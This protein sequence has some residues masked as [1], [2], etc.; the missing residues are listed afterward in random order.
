MSSPNQLVSQ[1]TQSDT[2][3][4]RLAYQPQQGQIPIKVSRVHINTTSTKNPIRDNTL[5][6]FINDTILKA[7]TLSD[8]AS[9]AEILTKRLHQSH[10]IKGLEPVF[11]ID[12]GYEDTLGATLPVAVQLNIQPTSHFS[13]KTGTNVTNSGQGDAYLTVQKR[14][15][16]GFDETI[17][18]D[19][20]YDTG[21]NSGTNLSVSWPYLMY[22]KNS[23]INTKLDIFDTWKSVGVRDLGVALTA[24]S[25]FVKGWNF[26]VG[27]EALRRQF[28][29]VKMSPLSELSLLMQ[30]GSF[31]KQDFKFSCVLDTRDNSTSPTHGHLTRLSNELAFDLQR[32]RFWKSTLELNWVTSFFRDNFITVSNTFK[33]GYIWNFNPMATYI[34]FTDKFQRGGPNDVRSFQIMGLGPRNL[35]YSLGGDAF[36]GYGTSVFSRIPIRKLYDSNFRLHWFFN[37]GKLIN[38]NSASLMSLMRELTS[39][40]STSVGVGLVL[41]HPVARF[42]LNFGVPV[43]VHSDDLARKGFQFGLGFDFL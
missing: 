19:H 3:P 7:Q 11:T 17:M 34:H 20:R 32:F 10:L 29:N 31:H 12:Q 14:G 26:E 13:A 5:A 9:Q 18:L 42:E 39:D 38:H 21:T 8:L 23:F 4:E 27:L 36:I 2:A 30:E 28:K 1:K 41:R 22:F 15:L 43:T 35:G 16:L 37:G 25:W 6:T 24:R 33:C 40:P